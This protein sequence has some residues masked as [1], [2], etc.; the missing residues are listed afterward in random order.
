MSAPE[1]PDPAIERFLRASGLL[2]PGAQARYRP[3]PGGV[4]SDIW[5]VDLPDGGA[6]CVKRALPRLKV[7]SHWEAP[8]SRNAAEWAWIGFAARHLPE[9][10]PRPLAHDPAASLFAIALLEPQQYPVWK[11]QLLEGRVEPATAGAVGAILGRLQAASAGDPD[12]ARAFDTLDHFQALRLEPYLLATARRHADLAAP[13]ERLAARTAATARA[14]VH[15]DVSPKNILVG[16]RGP[17]L[18][19]AECAWYGDPAFDL[20]FCLNHLL[21]KAL[22]PANRAP[23][24]QARLARAFEALTRAYFAE[25]RFEPRAALEARAADLLPGLMLARVDGKSPVEY[26]T[27]DAGRERVR[28]FARPR[29]ARPPARLAPLARAWYRPEGAR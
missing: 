14:L 22:V 28:A 1:Q 9:A 5:R 4:S 7:A 21:L 10:V 27:D 25:A 15:G 11:Q 16:P 29:I 19:D 13:L 17:V 6:L 3:L 18:L 8:V 2:A 24:Q 26:L 23:A 12:V 20:A